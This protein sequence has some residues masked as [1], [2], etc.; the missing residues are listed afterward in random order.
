VDAGGQKVEQVKPFGVGDGQVVTDAANL[1]ETEDGAVLSLA[2]F[3]SNPPPKVCR[4]NE[5]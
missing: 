5:P 2:A 1:S 3:L 4:M